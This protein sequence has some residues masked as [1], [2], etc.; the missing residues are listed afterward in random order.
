MSK[1]IQTIWGEPRIRGGTIATLHIYN[2][3]LTILMVKIQN[4]THAEKMKWCFVYHLLIVHS[5]AVSY[6]HLT[7][8]TIY[9]V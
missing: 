5:S 8:P 6:T 4:S 2:Y 7:L 1:I 3:A 9:S